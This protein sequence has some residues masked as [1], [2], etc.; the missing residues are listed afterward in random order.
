MMGNAEV[1]FISC[2]APMSTRQFIVVVLLEENELPITSPLSVDES[3][4]TRDIKDVKCLLSKTTHLL[5]E[6]CTMFATER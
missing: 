1:K 2:R 5:T 6:D 3:V 4:A